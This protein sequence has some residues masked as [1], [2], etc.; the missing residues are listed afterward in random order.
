MDGDNVAF[1]KEG[2]EAD[3]GDAEGFAGGIFFDVIGEEPASEAFEDGGG[4]LADFAGA[5]DA[6]GASVEIE[7]EEAIE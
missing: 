7:T 3:I 6:N 1:G 5:D 4:G 2:I